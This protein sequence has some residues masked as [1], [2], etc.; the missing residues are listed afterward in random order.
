[1]NDEH[2]NQLL[3]KLRVIHICAVISTTVFVLAFLAHIF[4]FHL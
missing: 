2:I 4:R 3:R 1:M